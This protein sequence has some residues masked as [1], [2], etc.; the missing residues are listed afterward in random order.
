MIPASTVREAISAIPFRPFRIRTANQGDYETPHP[1][2][3]T[4]SP[5]GR[6]L[7]IWNAD[8][9]ISIV[10]GAQITGIELLESG[11]PGGAER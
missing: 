1:D 2:W 3:L 5:K 9:G 7:G 8:G 10:D 11:H 4:I 6:S